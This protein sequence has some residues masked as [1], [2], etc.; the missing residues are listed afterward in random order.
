MTLHRQTKPYM[1]KFSLLWPH[2]STVNIFIIKW[3]S[4]LTAVKAVRTIA[5]LLAV[6]LKLTLSKQPST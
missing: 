1:F 4:Y 6:P 2:C 3:H 5:T